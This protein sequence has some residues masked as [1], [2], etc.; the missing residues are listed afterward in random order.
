M[1][2]APAP[3]ELLVLRFEAPG[4]HFEG[5][6]LG[7][8][9]RAESGDAIRVREAIYVGRDGT[10]GELQALRVVG[11]G[12]GGLVTALA[13]FRLDAERR[14]RLTAEALGGEDAATLRELGAD[15]QPGAA[16]VGILVEHAWH[17]TLLDAVAQSGGRV[18]SDEVLAP[19]AAGALADL[20]RGV[21]QASG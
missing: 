1:T 14:R 8:L 7:A 20:V 15:L 12:A 21:A 3:R 18:I 19:A 17:A 2:A 5:R 10:S 9:E 13:D 16:V 4:G 6:I 11:G